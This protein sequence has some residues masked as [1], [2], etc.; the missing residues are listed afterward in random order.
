M[1]EA[2]VSSSAIYV[3]IEIS[4]VIQPLEGKFS[5]K[6]IC[7]SSVGSIQG[8]DYGYPYRNRTRA[9]EGSLVHKL[10]CPVN[11]YLRLDGT[12]RHYEAMIRGITT[13]KRIQGTRKR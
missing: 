4:K 8:A 11:K 9:V 7:C 10:H 12:I 3:R 5:W 1:S 6:C 13:D 2:Y